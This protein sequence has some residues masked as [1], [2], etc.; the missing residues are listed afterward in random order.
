MSKRGTR[1]HGRDVY[2]SPR[3]GGSAASVQVEINFLSRCFLLSF[4]CRVISVN[5]ILRRVVYV[6][7]SSSL[8]IRLRVSFFVFFFFPFATLFHFVRFAVQI[9]P[10]DN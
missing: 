6:S 8:D 9:C 7:F 4:A 1:G 2:K 3:C 5:L 10:T